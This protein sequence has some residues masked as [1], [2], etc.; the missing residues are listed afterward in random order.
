MAPG[1]KG[2]DGCL[3][4]VCCEMCYPSPHK[5]LAL[6]STQ[7]DERLRVASSGQRM[8]TRLPVESVTPDLVSLHSVSMQALRWCAQKTLLSKTSPNLHRMFSQ[9]YLLLSPY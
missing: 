3:A 7:S 2:D 6:V 8:R 4:G 5:V 1:Q 9:H